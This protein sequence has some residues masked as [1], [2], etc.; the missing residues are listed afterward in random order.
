VISQGMFSVKD[1]RLE[2]LVQ[3]W[4]KHG[5]CALSETLCGGCAFTTCDSLGVGCSDPYTAARN[6]SGG[7]WPLGPK[8]EVNATTGFFPFPAGMSPS[9]GSATIRGRLQVHTADIDPDL[10]AGAVYFIEGQYVTEDDA[11][12]GNARNNASWRQITVSNNPPTFTVSAAGFPTFQLSPV[13]DAWVVQDGN[14]KITPILNVDEGGVG[15][16]G[17]FR[18]GALATDLGGGLWHYEYALQNQNSDR[19]GRSFSLPLPAGVQLTNIEFHDVDYHSGEPIS[20]TDW[21]VTVGASSVTWETQTFAANQN[22]NA[23]RWGTLYNFRFDANASPGLGDVTIGLFKPG[24]PADLTAA[25]VTAPVTVQF[26]D[27]AC[28]LSFGCL[29]L[30]ESVC[31]NNNGDFQ[32]LGTPCDPLPCPPAVP[33]NVAA[34][35]NNSCDEIDVSWNSVVDATDIEVYRNSVDDSGTAALINTV[36]GAAT[37]HV[38]TFVGENGSTWFYWVKACN[39]NGCSDFSSPSTSATLQVKGDFEPN[40][41]FDGRDING[42]VAAAIAGDACADLAD[43]FG[44]IDGADATAMAGLLV[45]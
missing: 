38:D 14:V 41:I 24:A 26:V 10:N 28:C 36:A 20:G 35:N 44:T 39:G 7:A 27:G 4:L 43:P 2:Q 33:E 17:R 37:S 31:N 16:H 45:P 25:N 30:S 40:G 6:G 32:G 5:F 3:A 13:I 8:S 15:V 12:A 18:M 22:A 1:G 9:G 23:L 42:F 11:L 34:A 29:E 19:S 21:S